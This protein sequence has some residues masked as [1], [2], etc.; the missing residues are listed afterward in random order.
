MI[1]K[2]NQCG[3][4]AEEQK[5]TNVDSCGCSTPTPSGCGCSSATTKTNN[6]TS[7]FISLILALFLTFVISYSL[8]KKSAKNK[9]AQNKANFTAIENKIK[10]QPQTIVYYF[11]ATKRCMS[12]NLIEKTTK[13][14]LEE[15]FTTQL[16]NGEIVF[17]SINFQKKPEL[18]KQ[19]ELVSSVVVVSQYDKNGKLTKFDRLDDVWKLKSDSK[20]FTKY[21]T[22]HVKS[23]CF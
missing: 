23:Y 13:E 9:L 11:H 22:A 18:A 20:K 14:V 2:K 4:K 17:K 8:G 3:C 5:S 1:D 6:S 21:I 15:K 7:K 12:C 19:F 16:K 10:Q